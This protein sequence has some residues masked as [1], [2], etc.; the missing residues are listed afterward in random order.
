M[1]EMDFDK[2]GRR[3]DVGILL[4]QFFFNE[5]TVQNIPITWK[6][7]FLTYTE[8]NTFIERRKFAGGEDFK[9]IRH[10]YFVMYGFKF[11]LFVMKRFEKSKHRLR[12]VQFARQRCQYN[13]PKTVLE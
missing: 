1:S 12:S 9:V 7:D 4:S 13:M 3:T 8:E 10:Y 6:H 2:G 11:F 5:A